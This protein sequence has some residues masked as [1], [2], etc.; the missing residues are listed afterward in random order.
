MSTP[1]STTTNPEY[2]LGGT[3]PDRPFTIITGHSGRYYLTE[4]DESFSQ[5]DTSL[6]IPS[7]QN[8]TPAAAA[9]SS[10]GVDQIEKRVIRARSDDLPE[11]WYVNDRDDQ[12]YKMG[13]YVSVQTDRANGGAIYGCRVHGQSSIDQVDQLR[14][15]REEWINE[16]SIPEIKDNTKVEKDMMSM[17]RS[18]LGLMWDYTIMPEITSRNY[19]LLQDSQTQSSVL[20]KYEVDDTSQTSN[21]AVINR[22][23][24]KY[25]TTF[26]EHANGNLDITTTFNFDS[27]YKPSNT[28]EMKIKTRSTKDDISMARSRDEWINKVYNR[29]NVETD[30]VTDRSVSVEK[31]ISSLADDTDDPRLKD[32]LIQRSKSAL[33]HLHDLKYYQAR[34]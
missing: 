4:N 32:H 27:D 33:G 2:K 5:C 15:E 14:L 7:S 29:G 25:E 9:T 12:T 6:L 17:M 18:K 16:M 10:T 31:Q 24:D 11:L 22:S 20:D 26:T 13:F 23:N 8:A 19:Y 28:G 3:K 30:T 21:G 1:T 34:Q